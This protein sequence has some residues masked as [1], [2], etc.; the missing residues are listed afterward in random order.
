MLNWKENDNDRNIWGGGGT[1]HDN[2]C[3]M[4]RVYRALF[5]IFTLRLRV[6]F[7]ISKGIYL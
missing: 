6:P 1:Q 5:V 2:W 7:S 3:V 4:R